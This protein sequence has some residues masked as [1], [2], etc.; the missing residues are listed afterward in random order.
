MG[1]KVPDIRSLERKL[2]ILSS[3][4][5]GGASIRIS[6]RPDTDSVAWF[7]QKK[8]LVLGIRSIST[9]PDLPEILRLMAIHELGKLRLNFPAD[10]ETLIAVPAPIRTILEEYRSDVLQR[11]SLGMKPKE[12]APFYDALYPIR[13]R[14][15]RLEINNLRMSFDP[16]VLGE[17]VLNREMGG[18]LSFPH[19]RF[20]VLMRF[21]VFLTRYR[22]FGHYREFLSDWRAAMELGRSARNENE[23]LTIAWEFHEKWKNVFSRSKNAGRGRSGAATETAEPKSGG[24]GSGGGGT[25]SGGFRNSTPSSGNEERAPWDY[26]PPDTTHGYGSDGANFS[27]SRRR[28]SDGNL[29]GAATDTTATLLMHGDIPFFHPA[30]HSREVFPWDQ[31][32]IRS[33]T[34]SLARFLKVGKE[35]LPLAGLTGRLISQKLFQPTFK[36]MNR[37]SPFREGGTELRILAIVDYSF[38][39]DG[40]PHY[41]ASHLTQVIHRSGIAS[42]FDVIASSSRFQFRMNPDHLNLLQPDEMEGFQNLLPMIDRFGHQYDAAIILTDCQISDKSADAL[43]VLRKKVMTIGCYVV[44]DEVQHVRGRPIEMVIADG[45]EMFPSTFLYSDTFH[46]LGRRLALTLNRMKNRQRS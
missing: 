3:R 28:G 46:G 15:K 20:P 33:E 30:P 18:H 45:R 39:M 37:P 43:G 11:E 42:T 36:V 4:Y 41:Y 34:K 9:R 16:Y 2:S 25:G 13:I 26:K 44:P 19:E 6:V 21:F 12:F 22:L 23:F 5:S 1:P 10:S 24:G 35:D 17:L 31:G 7:S 38:S 40:W 32:L 14:K 8:I 27:G 29:L